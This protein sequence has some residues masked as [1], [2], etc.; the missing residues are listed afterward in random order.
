MRHRKLALTVLALLALLSSATRALA[1]PTEE[2]YYEDPESFAT[3]ADLVLGTSEIVAVSSTQWEV[4]YTVRNIGESPAPASTAVFKLNAGNVVATR[5]VGAISGKSSRQDTFRIARSGCY[6]PLEYTLDTTNS[7]KESTVGE[8]NNRFF[9]VGQ[10]TV[11]CASA[12]KYKVKAKHFFVDNETNSW[13]AG[14]DEPYWIFSAAGHT[15]SSVRT[16]LSSV[17]TADTY[18]QISFGATEGCLNND[19]CTAD[20]LPYGLGLSI[21]LYEKDLGDMPQIMEDTG[22]FLKDAGTVMSY[23]PIDP[24]ITRSVT[25]TGYAL[26]AIHDWAE[27]DLIGSNVFKLSP[28]SLADKLRAPGPFLLRQTYAGAETAGG[29]RYTLTLEITRTQ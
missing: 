19:T 13:M 27:D 16:L 22:E 6:V 17:Y 3:P 5:P 29:G 8:G 7:V 14:S 2:Q 26:D 11:S 21:Q 15:A 12:P 1:A 20:F 4:R 25:A 24:W 23:M 9:I 28:G 10:A 18:N